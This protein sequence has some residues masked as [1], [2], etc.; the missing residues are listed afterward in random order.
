MEGSLKTR[1]ILASVM[2]RGTYVKFTLTS[3]GMFKER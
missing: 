1:I 3:L 2:L